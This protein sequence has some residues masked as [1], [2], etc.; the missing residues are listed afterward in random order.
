VRLVRDFKLAS[1]ASKLA[2]PADLDRAFIAVDAASKKASSGDDKGVHK[3]KGKSLSIAEFVHLLVRIAVARYVQSGNE[4]DV[5]AAMQRMMREDILPRSNGAALVESNVFRKHHCY[6]QEV[7]AVLRRHETTLRALYDCLATKTTQSIGNLVAFSTWTAFCGNVGLLDVDVSERDTSLCF[8]AARMCVANPYS[9]RGYHTSMGL[10]FEGWLEALVRIAC[11]KA[12]P[13]DEEIAEAGYTDAGAYFEWLAVADEERYTALLEQRATAWGDEPPQPVERQLD[14]LMSIILR[15]IEAET[16]MS[17]DSD[18]SLSA[19][20]A[21]K[22][23][24]KVEK[25]GR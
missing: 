2:K 15:R 14:H 6:K 23:W 25:K 12:L 22:W 5:S 20:E 19:R 4:T 21:R 16:T 7:D 17:K 1:K 24:E 10:P 3:D 9:L 11:C 13:T 8:S 18:G